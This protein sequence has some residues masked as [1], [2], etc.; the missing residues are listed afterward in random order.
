MS[1]RLPSGVEYRPSSIFGCRK[2]NIDPYVS[3][4]CAIFTLYK[5]LLNRERKALNLYEYLKICFNL[6]YTDLKF[7]L[8]TK[9]M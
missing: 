4:F 5:V 8:I 2:E 7:T 3:V 6:M 9:I 1:G